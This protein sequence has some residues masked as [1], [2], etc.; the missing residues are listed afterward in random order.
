MAAEGNF[1]LTWS[2]AIDVSVCSLARLLPRHNVLQAE[3]DGG[4]KFAL[5]TRHPITRWDSN[6]WPLW[7][8]DWRDV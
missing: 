8:R 5:K 6:I 3:G 2:Q 4:R 1:S 7:H